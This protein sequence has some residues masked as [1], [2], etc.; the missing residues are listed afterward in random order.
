MRIK[1]GGLLSYFVIGAVSALIAGCG[2]L[3][4]DNQN[5][6]NSNISKNTVVNGYHEH[7]V[8]CSLNI[9]R[10]KNN[11]NNSIIVGTKKFDFDADSVSVECINNHVVITAD[12]KTIFDDNIETSNSSRPS[13]TENLKIGSGRRKAE[14]RKLSGFSKI[15]ISSVGI[16]T[17]TQTGVESL[18][19]EADDNI[20]PL[21]T[22]E[23]TGGQLILGTKPNTSFKTNG[24]IIYNL[25]VK[26]LSFLENSG[27]TNIVAENIK[28]PKLIV[29]LSGSGD[30]KISGKVE[31]QELSIPGSARYNAV[32]LDSERA[33]VT[34]KGSG[35]ARINVSK[36]LDVT[37][38]GSGSVEYKGSAQV[39]QKITGSGKVKRD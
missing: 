36:T 24:Q 27:S 14:T 23:V 29:V 38:S 9:K 13:S 30:M 22:S 20:L 28:T 16:L 18:T 15:A 11:T 4:S 1:L 6:E 35:G 21:L 7:L 33:K 34:I 5:S 10:T 17:I 19:I 3:D 2:N 31:H 8:N 12:G 39:S 32:N 25:T 37:I 26:D